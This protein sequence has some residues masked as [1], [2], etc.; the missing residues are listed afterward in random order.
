MNTSDLNSAIHSTATAIA[1][2]PTLLLRLLVMSLIG[3]FCWQAI[4]G[5]GGVVTNELAIILAVALAFLYAKFWHESVV[6]KGWVK[7]ASIA[8]VL[9]TT[10]WIA[11]EGGFMATEK[12]KHESSHRYEQLTTQADAEGLS[13]QKQA[14]QERLDALRSEIDLLRA[15]IAELDTE[16]RSLAL[17]T[18]EQI[19]R[20][21]D[22]IA[23][24]SPA[25]I[26]AAQADRDSELTGPNPGRG[27]AYR[28]KD[29]IYND[30]KMRR[31]TE[32][33]GLESKLD[34]NARLQRQVDEKIRE[35]ARKQSTLEDRQARET[36]LAQSMDAI[37]TNLATKTQELGRLESVQHFLFEFTARRATDDT[38]GEVDGYVQKLWIFWLTFAFLGSIHMILGF[39]SVIHMMGPKEPEGAVQVNVIDQ[40]AEQPDNVLYAADEFVAKAAPESP[41]DKVVPKPI[42]EDGLTPEQW[43]EK[44]SAGN[45]VYIDLRDRPVAE[46]ILQVLDAYKKL[47]LID[48]DKMSDNAIREQL[49]R[50][51]GQPVQAYVNLQIAP[52]QRKIERAMRFLKHIDHTLPI[53][54]HERLPTCDRRKMVWDAIN[55]WAGVKDIKAAA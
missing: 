55:T 16:I 24:L 17:L 20:I 42:F 48:I 18:P 7:S 6:Q 33:P 43:D 30:L 19:Q 23:E 14:K 8:A 34:G 41:R 36:Q 49:A 29:A 13:T 39:A 53:T 1:K 47:E 38:T 37:Q 45:H 21:H 50:I 28:S 25:A 35:K 2:I 54:K 52:I 40:S 51:L 31:V 26:A 32:L 4:S 3:A 10:A 15:D 44:D 27:P 5:W 46:Y 9:I 11:M 22:Q 12:L